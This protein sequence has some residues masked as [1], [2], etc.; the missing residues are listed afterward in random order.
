MS[1]SLLTSILT[2]IYYATSFFHLLLRTTVFRDF[3]PWDAGYSWLVK[4]SA[5]AST[6]YIGTLVWFEKKCDV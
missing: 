6:V 3:A 1:S 5:K 4:S 2:S